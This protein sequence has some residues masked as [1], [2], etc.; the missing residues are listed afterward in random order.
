MRKILMATG[1]IFLISIACTSPTDWD[2]DNLNIPEFNFPKSVVF[3]KTLSAYNIFEGAPKD[4]IPTSNFHLLELSSTLFT[5]Y[6]QKQRLI[7]VPTGTQMKNNGDGTIDFPN[8]TILVKTFYYYHDER[9]PN[10]GKRIIESRLLIK[11]ND[12]WNAATYIWDQTQK[13]A[14]LELDGFDTKVKWISK[15]GNNNSIFYHLPRQNECFTCHQSN[16]AIT[17]LGPTLRNLNR[18]V[19]RND[20]P[21]NQI[22][23][24][25]SIGLINNFHISE[26]PTIVDYKNLEASL[27]ER[28]RAYLAMNC[29]HCHNPSGW[30]KANERR[31]DFRYEIPLGQTGILSR[32]EKIARTLVNGRMPYIGT[33]MID[34]EGI[35]LITAY[36]N[37][38]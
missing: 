20:E 25:Q 29:E 34:E 18:S 23:Y 17:P 30:K 1:L 24:L 26:M 31:F 9:D 7:K 21:I 6:A 8:G 14:R 11:E 12:T 32:R 22:T 16:S 27:A 36:L 35:R 37:S 4:L 5:D 33:T 19:Q 3:E 28:A 13:D 38:L 15:N 10:L 2:N